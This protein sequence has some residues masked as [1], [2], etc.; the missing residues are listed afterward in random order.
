MRSIPHCTC[1]VNGVVFFNLTICKAEWVGY[2]FFNDR[3]WA[4]IVEIVF[5]I[6]CPRK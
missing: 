1:V 6:L 5:D 2:Y 3:V 4:E